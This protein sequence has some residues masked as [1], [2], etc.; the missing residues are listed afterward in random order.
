MNGVPSWHHFGVNRKGD[1]EELAKILRDNGAAGLPL[2]TG[3]DKKIFFSDMEGPS[4]YGCRLFAY[5]KYY[6]LLDEQYPNSRFILN[7]RDV[8]D[9]IA[10]RARLHG[11]GVIE[12][13]K[14]YSKVETEEEVFNIW[15]NHYHDHIADVKEYFTERHQ[16]LLVFDIDRDP[17]S[18]L[19]KFFQHD[20][21]L[22]PRH[23]GIH[24]K[25]GSQP[26]N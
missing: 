21:T 13:E 14:K 10:S 26:W 17:I 22:D 9:W 2:L 11:G 4:H 6:K 25:R 1:S 24:N 7:I 23:W 5:S 15:R 18:K 12:G 8:D 3:V 16:D 20:I 19:I